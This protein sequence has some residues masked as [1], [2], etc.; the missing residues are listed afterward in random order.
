[1]S[2]S[3]KWKKDLDIDN[4]LGNLIDDDVMLFAH[5][6]FWRLY[7]PYVPMDTG[8]LLESVEITPK[9]VRHIVPYAAC[10]YYGSGF[11]FRHDK[12]PLACAYWD[13]VAMQTKKTELIESIQ[14]YIRSHS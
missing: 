4:I 9:Y 1:M 6:E 10:M 11:N 5:N 12:H 14:K 7:S 2:E 13:K 3:I 8:T